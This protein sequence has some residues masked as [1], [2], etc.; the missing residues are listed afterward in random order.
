M[1]YFCR[2]TSAHCDE[3]MQGGD[4]EANLLFFAVATYVE[5][6]LHIYSHRSRSFFCLLSL[7]LLSTLSLVNHP[8][9]ALGNT[10][11]HQSSQLT[12][13]SMSYQPTYGTHLVAPQQDYLSSSMNKVSDSS[14]C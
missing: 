8:R 11:R 7:A 5:R 13:L 4:G 3:K 9:T 1:G 14:E 2:S 10:S 12:I 6:L